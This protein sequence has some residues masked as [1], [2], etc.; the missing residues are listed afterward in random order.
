MKEEHFG[1]IWFIPGENKG[2]YPFCHSIYLQ[3]PGILIDP[4]SN[5]DRLKELKQSPGVN[6][7][8]LSH[9]HEDHFL[10]LDLFDGLPLLIS[11]EDAVQ[12]SNIETFLDGYG[13]EPQDRDN[14]RS[15]AIEMFHFRP[16][17]PDDF[18]TAGNSLTYGSLTINI[19]AAPGHT[20]GSV[21]LHFPDQDIL[22]LGDY[23]LTPFGPW[24]G[25]VSSSIKQTIASVK[26]LQHISASTCLASHGKG[27]F[28]DPPASLWDRYLGV[29]QSRDE[30]LLALL[31]KPCTIDDIVAAWIVYGKPREPLSLYAF[32]EKALMGKHL[33]RLMRRGDVAFENGNY[34]K[35]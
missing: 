4:A 22:F 21:A 9:W 23:D 20:P 34:L 25:D 3:G 27:I 13:I 31:E 24:Y 14:W 15:L 7:I 29:I 6:A 32:A 18:L 12:L 19:L 35:L 30:K 11:K 2:R 8:W 17:K 28:E 33:E 5:R 10:H 26:M 16:R 1:P